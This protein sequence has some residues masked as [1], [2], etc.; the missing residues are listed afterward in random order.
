MVYKES[1]WL[2]GL[3]DHHGPVQPTKE[4]KE[5]INYS[6]E[7]KGIPTCMG[8]GNHCLYITSQIWWSRIDHSTKQNLR[9][10]PILC[11]FGFERQKINTTVSINLPFCKLQITNKESDWLHNSNV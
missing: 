9:K 6:V 5:I 8:N 10:V 2:P 7:I 11:A 3:Y 4:G 1:S